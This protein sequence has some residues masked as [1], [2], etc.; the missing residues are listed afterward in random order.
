MMPK[1]TVCLFV[2]L[3]VVGFAIF[4]ATRDKKVKPTPSE[5]D[6]ETEEAG[7]AGEAEKVNK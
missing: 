7:E 2:I 5:D 3:S 6:D 1:H 4:Y